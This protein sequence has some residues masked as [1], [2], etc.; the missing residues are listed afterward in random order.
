MPAP[1]SGVLGGVAAFVVVLG[2]VGYFSILARPHPGDPLD[3][4]ISFADLESFVSAHEIAKTHDYAADVCAENY[5]STES[6]A[7]KAYMTFEPAHT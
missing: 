2:I 4:H 1:I 7:V 6:P 3:S 5:F